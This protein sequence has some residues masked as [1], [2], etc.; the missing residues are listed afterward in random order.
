MTRRSAARCGSIDPEHVARRCLQCKRIYA[1]RYAR[2][3][4]PFAR[5]I[6]GEIAECSFCGLNADNASQ[7]KV[8][9]YPL[10]RHMDRNGRHTSVCIGSLSICD[11]CVIEHARLNEKTKA[12][13]PQPAAR[14][15]GLRSHEGTTSNLEAL[16]S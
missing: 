10:L 2:G 6:R 4:P 3:D 7:V 16:A 11:R 12:G 15:D 9:R 14:E 13:L 5:I 8:L 1:R